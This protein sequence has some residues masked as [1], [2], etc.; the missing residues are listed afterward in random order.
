MSEIRSGYADHPGYRVEL[1]P[2]DVRVRAWQGDTLLAESRRTLLVRETA[3][4]EVIYFPERDVRLDLLRANDHH[5]RCPFKG[6]ADYYSLTRAERP[7]A[8]LAWTYRKPFP[9]VAGLSGHL[10][11][12]ADRVRIEAEGASETWQSSSRP[13]TSIRSLAAASSR[14]A[15]TAAAAT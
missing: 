11:F 3:H 4:R 2:Q 12:Y 9:E 8:N 13:S 10:A 7:E 1:V 6:E 15:S 5:T 14:S